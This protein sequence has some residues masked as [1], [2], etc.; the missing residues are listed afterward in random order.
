MACAALTASR[1]QIM[2]HRLYIFIVLEHV[3]ILLK[4]LLAAIVPDKPH[5]VVNS[6]A[7]AAFMQ[8]REQQLEAEEHS[9]RRQSASAARTR[10]VVD[11]MRK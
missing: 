9:V 3:L 5:W 7:K 2:A 10:V 8:R 6:E 11:H 4:V 1:P